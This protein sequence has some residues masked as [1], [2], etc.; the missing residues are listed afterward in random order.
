M[1]LNLNRSEM[2]QVLIRGHPLGA[3]RGVQTIPETSVLWGFS[4]GLSG[5]P[6]LRNVTHSQRNSSQCTHSQTS[7][8]PN[9]LGLSDVKGLT[10]PQKQEQSL[11]SELR[12]ILVP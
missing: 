4:E 11:T 5:L 1:K 12:L 7:I 6:S 9:Q 3:G 2:T 10:E 8:L